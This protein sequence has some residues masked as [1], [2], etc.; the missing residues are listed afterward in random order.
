MNIWDRIPLHILYVPF[1]FETAC[2]DEAQRNFEDQQIP[3]STKN[4]NSFFTASNNFGCSR[5]GLENTG[6]PFISM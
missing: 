6:A 3:C 4:L 1:D 5:R 2:I